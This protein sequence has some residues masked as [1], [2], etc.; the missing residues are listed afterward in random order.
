MNSLCDA[1]GDMG[2]APSLLGKFGSC[3]GAWGRALASD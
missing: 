2:E 3:D 1:D